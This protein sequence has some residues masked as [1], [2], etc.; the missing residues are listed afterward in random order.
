MNNLGLEARD[1]HGSTNE[2]L[3]E[4]VTS[5]ASSVNDQGGSMRRRAVEQKTA[6]FTNSS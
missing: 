3:N 2:Y 1:G 6:T 5:S 4:I